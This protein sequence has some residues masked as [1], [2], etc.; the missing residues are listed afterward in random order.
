MTVLLACYASMAVLAP[1]LVR[2]L[3]P[4][5]LYAVAAVPAATFAW[6]LAH[7]GAMRSGGAV[8]EVH[9]WVPQL[10][11]ELAFRMTAFPWLM[12]LL[13]SGVGALVLAYSAHYFPAGEAGLG[14]F[15]AVFVGFAGAML[16][17]VVADDLLLLYVFWELTSV[18]SYLLIGHDPT[19]RAS[20]WAA[21]QALLVTTLGGLAML[22]GFIML[23]QHAGTYRLSAVVEDLPGGAYLVVA[24]V[25]VLL[26][27][28]SKSAL[29]PFSFWLPNAMAA[30]TPVSAYLHAAAMV[31]A[32]V[33]LIGMLT[34]VFA[35]DP[36]WRE[37]VWACGAL[38]FLFGGWTALRQTDLK[39]MLAYGTVSQL[40]MIG[41]VLGSGFRDAALAGA[42]LLAG[43]AMFKAALFLVV[44]IVDK[45]TGTREIYSLSGLGARRPALA[46][47]A[48]L[49]VASM[50]GL[51]PTFGFVAKE[52]MLAAFWDGGPW[53]RAMLA[54]LVAGA[55]LTVAY[56][57]RFLWGA[58][59]R[60]P[61]LDDTDAA[62]AGP[63]FLAA[64]A[65]LALAGLAAGLLAPGADGLLAPYADR[66]P[67]TG[68]AYHLALWHGLT[69]ALGLSLAALAAGFGL[70]LATRRT[71]AWRAVKLR[72][73]SGAVYRQAQN[74]I[75]RLAVELTGRTQRGSLPFYLGVILVSLVVLAGG[76]LLFDGPWPHRFRLFDTPLQL[77]AG[78]I[79]VAAAIAAALARRRLTAMVLTGVSGYGVAALFIFHG[80]PDLALTQFLVETVTIVM[81]VLVLRRLPPR[82]SERPLKKVRRFRVAIGVAVGVVAAGMAYV[83][84][85]SREAEP[86]SEL[87]PDLA[88]S[89][90]GGHN[91]V[92]VILVDI[93]AWDTMGEIAVLLVAATGVASLI[94]GRDKAM[95]RRGGSRPAPP[96]TGEHVK[97]LSRPE[98][99][100]SHQAI[101][102]QVVTRLLFH[103]IVLFSIYLLFTGHNH[104]G[105]GFAGGLVAGLALA[106]RYLA[107]GRAELN[108]A[109]PVDAGRL[110]GTG[111]LVSVGTGAAS[112]L[113]GGQVLQSAILDVEVPLLGHLHFVTSTFF[114]IGV[115]LI[116]V[117]LVL[118]ILRSLGAE[119]D[120]HRE[121]G[122]GPENAAP[123]P[124]KEAA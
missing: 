17:L 80:A 61:G 47:V 89:Y 120:R 100:G 39:L 36:P 95:H 44:G 34:P 25:M 112:M 91:I 20:R 27:A 37:A 64:P 98:T 109:A 43:H 50:I 65:L 103:T 10:G 23:G 30:P 15:A 16:G 35:A 26:G 106:V 31:K 68:H 113:L 85:G 77:A 105:G 121:S 92:N 4:K 67:D 59:A 122:D 72:L 104:P 7:T 69:P 18:F 82:F 74:G 81:F 41:I 83:A 93:R 96:K 97:W 29:F 55:A 51:P 3:G 40:G 108:A 42:A 110:L 107:G 87:F 9:P 21:M 90:G 2:W 28:L 114:D 62:P 46:A 124:E 84:V 79:I 45:T 71:S 116:V 33:F 54:C 119:I 117:G 52:A 99:D 86:I 48:V 123:L 8:T 53:E 73:T 102:L 56:G 101:I 5:A 58:F 12:V 78:G 115:Y 88:V 60:K 94:F 11:Q 6:A 38:T 49:A 118:D 111:L 19:R 32:G 66:Y 76:L 57:L 63:G 22:V 75:D 14:R 24:L 70:Y 13:V 1:A